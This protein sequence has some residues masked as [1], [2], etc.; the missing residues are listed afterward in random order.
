MGSYT[1]RICAIR[2]LTILQTQGHV[3]YSGYTLQQLR[4]LL[5]VML[6]CCE[7]PQKHHLAIFD[8][9]TEKRFKRASIFVE[10]EITKGFRLPFASRDSSAGNGLLWKRK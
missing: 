1:S 10:T 8:K 2:L 6:E 5:M 9:Y 4:Q 7:T 3:H